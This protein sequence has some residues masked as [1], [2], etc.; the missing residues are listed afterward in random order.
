MESCETCFPAD[1]FAKQRYRAETAT[2]FVPCALIICAFSHKFQLES[3]AAFMYKMFC[4]TAFLLVGYFQQF[5]S[6]FDTGRMLLIP[7]FL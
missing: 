6:R 2:F 7:A 5:V 4:F 1:F 3:F